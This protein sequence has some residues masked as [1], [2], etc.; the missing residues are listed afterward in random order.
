VLIEGERIC[1]HAQVVIATRAPRRVCDTRLELWAQ[2]LQQMT[3]THD[4][5]AQPDD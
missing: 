4:S 2:A 5:D 1:I 3:K